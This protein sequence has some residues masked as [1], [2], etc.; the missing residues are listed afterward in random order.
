MLSWDFSYHRLNVR[1]KPLEQVVIGY[2][3]VVETREDQ[4]TQIGG[5]YGSHSLGDPVF[6][7]RLG[8]IC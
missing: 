7:C 4:Y 1:A 5:Y 8:L 2:F 3:F 6:I